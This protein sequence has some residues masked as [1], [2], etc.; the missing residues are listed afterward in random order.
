[1]LTSDWLIILTTNTCKTV[2]LTV[3]FS[4]ESFSEIS[5]K[6]RELLEDDARPGQAHHVITP[7][8][9]AEVNALV[10]VNHRITVDEIK[11]LLC[12]SVDTTRLIMREHFNFRKI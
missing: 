5:S 3:V 10:F 9:I 11:Q 1:M 6:G 2:H 8:M 7:K 4:Y 12:I